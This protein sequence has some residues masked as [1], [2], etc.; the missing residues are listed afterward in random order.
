ML[1]LPRIKS[2][3]YQAFSWADELSSWVVPSVTHCT[4][5]RWGDEQSVTAAWTP[6]GTSRNI[7]DMMSH[8]FV[9]IQSS[10]DFPKLVVQPHKA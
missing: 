3:A 2:T 8:Q 9:L 7:P 4:L 5:H 10:L 1:N 6:T